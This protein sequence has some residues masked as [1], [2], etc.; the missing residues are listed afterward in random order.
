[1]WVC[2]WEEWR[3]PNKN[4]PQIT[5]FNGWRNKHAYP[6]MV[7]GFPHY[8]Q[9]IPKHHL[10]F[11]NWYIMNDWS[12][13]CESFPHFLHAVGLFPHYQPMIIPSYWSPMIINPGDHEPIL[14]R[15]NDSGSIPIFRL[16]SAIIFHS[17]MVFL[18]GWWSFSPNWAVFVQPTA[19]ESR[20][21]AWPSGVIDNKPGI[22]KNQVINHV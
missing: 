9:S 20:K 16:F 18:R 15:F 13:S 10:N 1:M 8:Q 22:R 2:L 21:A 3:K 6:N 11:E 7:L 17:Q 5:V 12:L 4:H 19:K 14:P